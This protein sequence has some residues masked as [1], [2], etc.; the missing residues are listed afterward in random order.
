MS[1]QNVN[2]L[3]Y[4]TNFYTTLYGSC[5]SRLLV[6][7]LLL[8]DEGWLENGGCTLRIRVDYLVLIG[9]RLG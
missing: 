9:L 4:R 3:P 1:F 6:C 7:F 2:F 5:R 8:N